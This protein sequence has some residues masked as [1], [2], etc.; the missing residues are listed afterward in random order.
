LLDISN[1][2]EYIWTTIFDPSVPKSSTMPLPSPSS[3]S[4]N[5]SNNILAGAILG[6][7]LSGILLSIGSFFIYK[8]NKNRQEQKTIHGNENHDDYNQEEKE[9]HIVRDIHNN[10]ATNNNNEQEIIQIPS[11]QIPRNENTTNHEPII[12]AANDYHGQEIIQNENYEPAP[13]VV[14]TNYGQ[15]IISTPNNNRLSSQ[16]LKDEILQSVKQEI[17]QNLK[18]D[19]LQAVKQEIGQ[20]LKSDILQAIREENFNNAKSDTRQN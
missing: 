14:N 8:W 5:N 9:L 1:N 10:E 13:T 4:P 6:S 18:N 16:I 20:N 15:E 3:L 19:I 12:I 17:G 2:D 7:L 11:I